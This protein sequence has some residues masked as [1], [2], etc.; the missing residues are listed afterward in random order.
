MIQSIFKNGL[1][2]KPIL[3]QAASFCILLISEATLL[4]I[5]QIY[6][7]VKKEN[8]YIFP[9]YVVSTLHS[10]MERLRKW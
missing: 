4:C 3:K 8:V 5:R 6:I 9:S 1:N 10:M 2:F 7:F